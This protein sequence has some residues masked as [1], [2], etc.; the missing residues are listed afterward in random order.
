MNLI[1]L[2]CPNCHGEIKL[3]ES[4][5]YGFCMYCGHK[6]MIPKEQKTIRLDDSERVSNLKKLLA[7]QLDSKNYREQADLSRRILEMD[8]SCSIAWFVKG[9]MAYLDENMHDCLLYWI[10]ATENVTDEDLDLFYIHMV[11]M[12]GLAFVSDW[13]TAYPFGGVRT[14]D[15]NILEKTSND[16]YSSFFE[17]VLYSAYDNIRNESDSDDIKRHSMIYLVFTLLYASILTNLDDVYRII[18]ECADREN[19]FRI[20]IDRSSIFDKL[21]SADSPYGTISNGID[22]LMV[23]SNR[24]EDAIANLSDDDLNYLSEYWIEGPLDDYSSH[25]IEGFDNQREMAKSSLLS[26]SKY[27][28][29]RD[30]SID[31]YIRGYL[32]PLSNRL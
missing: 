22:Y 5:E 4:K 19:E 18:R 2:S 23:L 11:D 6:V 16:D 25:I 7:S 21:S 27:K 13:M 20:N 12:I 29:L 3:D 17:D 8:A 28:R 31:D 30:G 24:L 10:N 32:E 14:I 1:D 26:A 9:R 15:D